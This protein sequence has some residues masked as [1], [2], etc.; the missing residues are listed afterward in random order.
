MKAIGE[1]YEIGM[2]LATLCCI[3]ECVTD[4]L[5][6]CFCCFCHCCCCVPCSVLFCACI[7]SDPS[8]PI[9]R[10]EAAHQNGLASTCE[11]PL[12]EAI[13]AYMQVVLRLR[14]N[15]GQDLK[16]AKVLVGD[17]RGCRLVA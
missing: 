7:F 11:D 14:P 4:G 6:D 3:H 10:Y 15:N 8:C 1:M 13:D 17:N 12:K 2:P 5:M 9:I 16:V